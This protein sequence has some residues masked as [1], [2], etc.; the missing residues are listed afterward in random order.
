MLGSIISDMFNWMP[1]AYVNV[2]SVG[3]YL[4]NLSAY[5]YFENLRLVICFV[6]KNNPSSLCSVP[7]YSCQA[8]DRAGRY[9]P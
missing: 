1:L 8:C 5:W 7:S 6:D 9:P 2:E 3:A 4:Q